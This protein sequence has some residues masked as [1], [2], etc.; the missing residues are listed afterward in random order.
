M[1]KLII[2]FSLFLLLPI[3]SQQF[4]SLTGIED[5]NGST[6]LLYRSGSQYYSYNPI[7]KFNTQ[8]LSESLLIQAYSIN[9]PSGE[10]SKAV[11][12]F[13]FFS[14][15]ETDFMNVGFE[16]NPDKHSFIA[17]NDTIIFGRGENFIKVDISKQNSQKVF[18]FG[19]D[20]TFKSWDGGFTF[21][22]DTIPVISEFI[23]I[24][25]SG[26]DD[27]VLF[28]IDSIY[29][30]VKSND[31]G[32]SSNIVDTSKVFFDEYFKMQYDYNK[33]FVYRLNWSHGK[34][35]L[36]VSNNKGNAFTWSKVYESEHPIY[37]AINS[38]ESGVIYLT[39]GKQI[40]KS[41]N[42]GFTFVPF[43]K[44]PQKLI[45]IYKKP[46]S[47]ILYAAS[48][49][50]LFE[51]RTDSIVI[52]KS[53]PVSKYDLD[54]Y[55]LSEGN[56][57]IYAITIADFNDYFPNYYFYNSY[58]E[59]LKDTLLSNGESYFKI[60][61]FIDTNDKAFTYERIDST[62]GK[63]YRFYDQ[64]GL[65]SDEYLIDDLLAE[66][67][68][69]TFS[70]RMHEP[71]NHLFPVICL[72][73]SIFSKWNIQKDEKHFRTHGDLTGYSY[74]LIE[75][76]GLDSINYE[77]DFGY[78]QSFLKGC[79]INGI[80]Y[81]DTSFVLGV[82]DEV[83]FIPE[84]FKLNQN[85]PNPFNP[86]TK[87][88]YQLPVAGNVTL[89]VFDVLGKEVALIVDDYRNAGSYNVEFSMN[90]LQL[91]SGIYFYQIKVSPSESR[92]NSFTETKKMILIK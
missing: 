16:I 3:Y 44:L 55:P 89:K 31:G 90:N 79:V 37:I 56:K 26:F 24:S 91:S 92:Q 50:S 7:Y 63:V 72:R 5:K 58:R 1:K 65:T 62:T 45:G 4:H 29:N 68:D 51:V 73:Q 82:E 9:Y 2:F 17:R 8:S 38:S 12:D 47:D 61:S 21:I 52:L 40:Y 28:G 20:G 25:L 87:I 32:A 48:K 66:V 23:P 33:L 53:F 69:T 67:G 74:R 81:G 83:S 6:I 14:N 75:N 13:E 71:Y 11:L 49:Y 36:N 10:L 30:F 15:S 43:R 59:V 39:D 18:V 80:V 64:D 35:T 84:K 34:Y 78:S 54:Y 86:S 88:S 22:K 42:G 57:W 19:S 41:S 70:S 60:I 46:N 76:I 77:W 27:K 85:Y